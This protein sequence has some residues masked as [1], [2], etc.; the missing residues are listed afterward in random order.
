LSILLFGKALKVQAKFVLHRSLSS[1]DMT[2]ISFGSSSLGCLDNC[3]CA[4]YCPIDTLSSWSHSIG[5]INWYSILSTTKNGITQELFCMKKKHVIS[6]LSI[7]QSLRSFS[8]IV[9]HCRF[10]MQQRHK[11]SF[12]LDLVS[13]YL[14]HFHPTI[15]FIT[16]AIGRCSDKIV[17]Y[18]RLTHVRHSFFIAMH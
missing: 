8:P 6:T 5:L 12:L 3:Y 13:V 17:R 15:N 4:L 11:S 7:E 14:W 1:S 10:G 16:I 9:L 2:Y 18:C